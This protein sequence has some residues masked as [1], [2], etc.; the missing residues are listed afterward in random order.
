MIDTHG[1]S[2]NSMCVLNAITCNLLHIM[3]D[4]YGHSIISKFV[5]IKYDYV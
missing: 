2:I 4:I 5:C 3:I 1:Y